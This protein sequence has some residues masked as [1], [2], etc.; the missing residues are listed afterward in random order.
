[1]LLQGVGGTVQYPRGYLKKAYEAVRQK[2]GLCI[3]DEVRAGER[4]DGCVLVVSDIERLYCWLGAVACHTCVL[5]VCYTM[6]ILDC[7]GVVL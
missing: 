2:G 7:G 3:A 6:R 5:Q 4:V 1:M